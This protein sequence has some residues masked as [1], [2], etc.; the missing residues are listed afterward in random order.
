MNDPM[1]LTKRLK[2]LAKLSGTVHSEIERA[3]VYAATQT[4]E[5]QFRNTEPEL[6]PYPLEKIT[7]ACWSIRAAIG[8]DVTNGHEPSS[9]VS[10]AIGAISTFE[11]VWR[12]RSI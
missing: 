11:D 5:D 2:E 7:S 4:I 10:W 8:Y 3:A 1:I 6:D 12:E 9:H